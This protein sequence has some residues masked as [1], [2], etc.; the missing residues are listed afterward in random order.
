VPTNQ[1]EFYRDAIVQHHNPYFT[2]IGVPDP[3][4]QTQLPR[5]IKI[6]E[7]LSTKTLVEELKG[8]PVFGELLRNPALAERLR[9]EE[10][11][12]QGSG[13]ISV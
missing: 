8:Y 2:Y 3:D 6:S 1:I 11:A 7:T 12:G 10:E 4:P 13:N 5:G 9:L